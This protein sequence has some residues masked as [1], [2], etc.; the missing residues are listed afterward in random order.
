MTTSSTADSEITMEC[1]RTHYEIM[2]FMYGEAEA[3]DDPQRWSEW[4]DLITD[5]I[6]YRIPTRI[7]R[8]RGASQPQFSR[9]SYHL[10]EDYASLKSRIDRLE[11]EYAWSENPPV[12]AR[13]FIGN[14][15]PREAGD[16]SIEATSNILLL[17]MRKDSTEPDFVSAVRDDTYTRDNGQLK[18]T[19][20]TVHL[21]HTSIGVS[22]LPIL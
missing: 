8:E 6:E 9:E 5:D 22:H 14:I 17:Q 4:L 21:D 10:N 11:S 19:E 13:R 16:D 1:I 20:R 7:T 12:R 2:D 18:L 15:R 3:L